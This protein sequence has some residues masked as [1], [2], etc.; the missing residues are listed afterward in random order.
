MRR[1]GRPFKFTYDV[2]QSDSAAVPAYPGDKKCFSIAKEGVDKSIHERTEYVE[3]V[4]LRAWE[5]V[6]ALPFDCG[7]LDLGKYQVG[8]EQRICHDIHV[9]KVKTELHRDTCKDQSYF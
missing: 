2:Y 4:K 7:Q 9:K 8:H 5:S 6:P 3:C 1:V